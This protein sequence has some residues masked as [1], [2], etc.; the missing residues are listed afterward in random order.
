LNEKSINVGII[1]EEYLLYGEHLKIFGKA[2]DFEG[3]EERSF[4]SLNF[5]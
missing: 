2:R 3:G 4:V 1:C 5:F